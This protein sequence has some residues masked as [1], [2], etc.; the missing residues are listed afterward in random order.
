[1]RASFENIIKLCETAKIPH[2]FIDSTCSV[3]Y[4]PSSDAVDVHFWLGGM[5]AKRNTVRC[6]PYVE[7]ILASRQEVA[8]SLPTLQ[9]LAKSIG[10]VLSRHD[11][12]SC[13]THWDI[14]QMDFDTDRTGWNEYV[15][16][17]Q[18]YSEKT[19]NDY[20]TELCLYDLFPTGLVS[21]P[22]EEVQ[23]ILQAVQKIPKD[24]EFLFAMQF[25]KYL[26]MY[27]NPGSS[28]VL[29]YIS[30]LLQKSRMEFYQVEEEEDAPEVGDKRG[31]DEE[32]IY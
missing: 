30:Q 31:R 7:K 28:E 15:Y 11:C 27:G 5:I 8:R 22:E 19:R 23:D 26:Y 14:D 25:G 21:Y 17:M 32:A 18:V 9:D 12:P 6:F 20:C 2:V 4:I 29:N 3:I 24:S 16:I 1:M 13:L 10:A